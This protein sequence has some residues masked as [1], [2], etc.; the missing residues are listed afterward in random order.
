MKVW[1]E[2]LE[3]AKTWSIEAGDKQLERLEGP[4]HM[5]SKS[6]AIDLVTEMDVWTEKFL[7]EKIKKHYPDHVMRTEEGGMH[8]GNSDFEWIIDPIDGTVNYAHGLPHFSISIG[9]RFKGTTVAGM[10]YA[11]KLQEMYEAIKGG[12]AYLNEKAITVSETKALDR[13]VVGTGFPYDKGTDP[14]NNLTHFNNILPK[15][16]GIRRLGGAA[17]DLSQVA[18]G[19]MDGYWEIKLNSWDIEAG[20]L[21]LEEAGGVA[22][23]VKEEKGLFV[24]SGSPEIFPQL[25]ALIE[26]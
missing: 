16:G 7:T 24:I 2:M 4:M 13:A 12:G 1:N 10:V 26:R 19:R 6:S 8:E 15:I 25:K 11:P 9:I 17:L 5:E 3:H 20:L 23:V 18:C 14:D 21:I 22:E